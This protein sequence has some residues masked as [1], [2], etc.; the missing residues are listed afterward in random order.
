M[1]SMKTEAALVNRLLSTAI[2][3][4]R[5]ARSQKTLLAR[6]STFLMADKVLAAVRG[7]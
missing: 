4:I 7:S 3:N 2:G 6:T 1:T 5:K